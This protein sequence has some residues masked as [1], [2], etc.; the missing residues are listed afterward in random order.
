MFHVL[1]DVLRQFACIFLLFSLTSQTFAAYDPDASMSKVSNG[2]VEIAY[3]DVGEK[4]ADPILIIMGLA[5]SHRIWNPEI[6]DGLLQG[7]YRVVLLD[8]RDVGESSRVAARG[9]LWL[10]WQL[11]KYRIGWRVKSPY[12][13]SD[14]AR[15]ATTV[16]DA[17]EIDRAHLIGASLG[18]MIAQ[19][20]AYE[21]PTRAASLVSIMSTTWAPHLPPPGQEQQQG[22]ADMNESSDEE[23]ER[24]QAFGFYPDALPNQVT[25]ILSAGDRT[26]Q[27][28]TIVAPTL[29]LHGAEDQLLSVEHGEHTAQIIPGASFK[30][31][32]GMG[33][34]LPEPIVPELVKDMLAH[35]NAHPIKEWIP[36]DGF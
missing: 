10:A 7:G 12:S 29:V 35:L 33:H 17:L 13:L 19:T 1:C 32:H 28:A 30:V 2:D 4:S 36:S 23:A 6:I 24:L 22:I 26:N 16:L 31:Y 27:V 34:D 25:A 5:A 15:D 11:F 3:L 21:H 18:G 8:N 14:M 9:K 20:I